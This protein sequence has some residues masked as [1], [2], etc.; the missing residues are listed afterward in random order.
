MDKSDK[1]KELRAE[2]DKLEQQQKKHD[3]LPEA[4]KLAELIH[5]NKCRWNHTDGCSWFYGDWDSETLGYAREEYLKKART[6][7]TEVDF[8]TAMKVVKY[9]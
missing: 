4:C 6:I 9:I 8:E 2:A 3:R 5:E 1:I 7:L